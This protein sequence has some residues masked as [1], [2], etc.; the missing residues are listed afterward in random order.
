MQILTKNWEKLKS[1]DLVLLRCQKCAADFSLTKKR[2]KDKISKIGVQPLGGSF[3]SF[4]CYNLYR[5]TF[6]PIFNCLNCGYQF[7]K[8][9]SW[10]K[11]SKNHFCGNSCAA[12]YHNSHK[13]TGTRRSKLEVWLENKLT[14]L[15]PDLEIHF[16]RKS[17]INSELDIYIPSLK[18][19]FEL[20][21]IFHYEPVF[22]PEKLSK[23]QNNDQRKF[24]ACAENG[25]S[26][27]VIDTS[28]QRRFT[29]L[30]S[31]KFLNIIIEIIKRV[32][33]GN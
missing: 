31:L 7:S 5:T 24:Q 2:V 25:V 18:L 27:C 22:G 8:K 4:K 3:C 6:H 20:N 28:G 9:P 12:I 15:Y 1:N 11:K 17:A 29:E 33:N 13:T 21:G 10:V 14:E 32:A 30:S 23:T 19:A 16:N 26:L